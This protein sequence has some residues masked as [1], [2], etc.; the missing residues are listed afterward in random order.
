MSVP[1]GK[2]IKE[3][4]G[5]EY[6]YTQEEWI[7]FSKTKRSYIRHP[8]THKQSYLNW[9]AKQTNE[10]HRLRARKSQLKLSYGITIEEYD[11]MLAQQDYK[12]AICNTD[13]PTGKWKVFAVDHCH[14]TGEVRGLLC[15]EC[16]RGMGLLRDNA[17]LLRKAADYLDSHKIKSYNEGQE[18]KM[19]GNQESLKD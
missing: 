2:K 14:V 18:R 3:N 1:K 5:P 19:N 17:D 8:E 13:K 12:C 6:G 4:E 15:N 11:V 16:N 7:S 9:A 10:Y